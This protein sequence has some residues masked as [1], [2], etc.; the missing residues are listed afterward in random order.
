MC[1]VSSGWLLAGPA[2]ADSRLNSCSVR[3]VA[4]RSRPGIKLPGAAASCELVA[5]PGSCMLT[6]CKTEQTQ[7]SEV[8]SHLHTRCAGPGAGPRPGMRPD[9]QVSTQQAHNT[10]T[11]IHTRTRSPSRATGTARASHTHLTRLRCT[12]YTI[13]QRLTVAS[14]TLGTHHVK[15]VD[16]RSRY[17]TQLQ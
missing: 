4:L 1:S 12:L 17:S 11:Y 6:K 2:K 14:R 5:C 8:A 7:R 13:V 3:R 10:H 15:P 16:V 9:A